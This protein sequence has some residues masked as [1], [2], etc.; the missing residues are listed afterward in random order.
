MIS[1]FA[2]IIAIISMVLFDFFM[3][4][5]TPKL[6]VPEDFRVG[7]GVFLNPVARKNL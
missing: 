5:N 3:D 1:D 2:V 6:E 4:I 7:T